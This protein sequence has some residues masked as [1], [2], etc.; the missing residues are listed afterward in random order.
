MFGKQYEFTYDEDRTPI[1]NFNDWLSE[2]KDE[3]FWEKDK[4]YSHEEAVKVF[5][6]YYQVKLNAE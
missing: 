5:E 3:R 1:E 6:Q 2:N 4:P